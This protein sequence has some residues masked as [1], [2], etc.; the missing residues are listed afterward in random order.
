MPLLS[1]ESFIFFERFLG[2]VF[3]VLALLLLVLLCIRFFIVSPAIVN[4]PS[5]EPTYL[6]GQTFYVNRFHYLFS[7]PER[8][9]IV[10]IVDP[11][12]EQLYIKRVIGLP[13]ETIVLKRRQVYLFD[14]KTQEDMLLEEPYLTP[15]RA[16][17]DVAGQ[18]GALRFPLGAHEYFVAG[19]NRPR[20]TDSRHYG[21]VSRAHIV[22]RVIGGK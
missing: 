9:D 19:D 21:P 20:S 18:Q 22:G 15:E 5:M 16:R 3:A 12:S 8:F 17:S 4:G 1:R 2:R 6:D 11:E 10:Q 13:G 14:E 7:P